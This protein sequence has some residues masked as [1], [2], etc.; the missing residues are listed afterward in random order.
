MKLKIVISTQTVI[1][2]TF[3]LLKY[4]FISVPSRSKAHCNFRTA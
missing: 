4:C 3:L 2:I 1:L